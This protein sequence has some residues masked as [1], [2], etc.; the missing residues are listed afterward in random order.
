MQDSQAVPGPNFLG[1]TWS[2]PL[3]HWFS[4][5]YGSQI[6]IIPKDFKKSLLVSINQDLWSLFH[7]I[8]Y[9][10]LQNWLVKTGDLSLTQLILCIAGLII[11]S[12]GIVNINI[13]EFS[14]LTHCTTRGKLFRMGCSGTDVTS[15]CFHP[16]LPLLPESPVWEVHGV[17][18]Y[19]T[20][21]TH[22][23]R[24]QCWETH[25][26]GRVVVTSRWVQWV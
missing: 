2:K 3:V 5:P 9:V 24:K 19:P 6:E 18:T 8:F 17:P 10:T 22:Y 26:H 11:A 16:C 21:T 7:V 23:S 25:G 12:E 15:V 1:Q 20:C 13:Y 4:C 14:S